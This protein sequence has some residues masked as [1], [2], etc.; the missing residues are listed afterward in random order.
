MKKDPKKPMKKHDDEMQDKKL[1]NKMM[2]KE[3]SKMKKSKSC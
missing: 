3:K 2:K 1:F